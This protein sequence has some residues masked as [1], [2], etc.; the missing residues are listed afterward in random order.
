[1]S[2][3]GTACILGEGGVL[4]GTC[5]LGPSQDVHTRMGICMN[6]GHL[7]ERVVISRALDPT[8]GP[9]GRAL[10]AGSGAQAGQGCGV[11]QGRAVWPGAMRHLR[12]WGLT[13]AWLPQSHQQCPGQ[14]D[15]GPGAEPRQ[16]QPAAAE[17]GAGGAQLR[18]GR[19][20][21]VRVCKDAGRPGGVHACV[22]AGGCR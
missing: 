15:G 7:G 18:H 17:G 19:G 14:G 2:A 3:K 1:M 13:A 6:L 5:A 8:A 11:A 9:W 20:R 21:E 4:E 22:R 16:L 10:G 12:S